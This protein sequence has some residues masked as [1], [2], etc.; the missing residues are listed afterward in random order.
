MINSI[1]QIPNYKHP[2]IDDIDVEA[3]RPTGTSLVELNS[4]PLAIEQY[5]TDAR[6]PEIIKRINGQTIIYTEYVGTANPAKD[7]ILKK[8]G[9]AVKEKKFTYGCYTGYDHSCLDLFSE[10][11]IQVLIASRPIS[12]GIDGL[13][14][15]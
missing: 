11:K 10:K 4:R 12:T 6:I 2:I 15:V 13:Q 14:Q 9:D 7:P 3:E 1:R 5:L 8:I